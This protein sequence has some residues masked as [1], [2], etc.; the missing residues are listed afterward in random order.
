MK[1]YAA[2]LTILLAIAISACAKNSV[3]SQSGHNKKSF[4]TEESQRAKDSYLAYEHFFTIDTSNENISE[5]Y[6]ATL[7]VCTNNKDLHCTVL[8]SQL[9]SGNEPS[10]YIKIRVKPEGI[11]DL[12]KIAAQKGKIVQESTHIEDLATPILDNKQR[13]DMLNDQ[14]KRLIDLQ[15]KSVD[16]LDA[17]LKL[18]L[19][20]SRLQSEIEYETG[21]KEFLNQRTNLD[22]VN[23]N[24]QVEYYQSF[25]KPIKQSLSEFSNYL[26]DGIAGSII[27]VAYLLPG[28]I[29]LFTL[30]MVLRAGLKKLKKNQ[31]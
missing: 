20:I 18:A 23:F 31:P 17:L 28:M 1:K 11:K 21:Q 3:E 7:D 22:I 27:A 26:S 4:A 25:W 10:A 12:I 30:F 9:S 5:S 13:L 2:I 24:F 29:V 15:E 6:Y 14:K 19:E 8:D 16:N